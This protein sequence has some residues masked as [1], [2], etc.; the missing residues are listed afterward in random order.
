MTPHPLHPLEGTMCQHDFEGRRLFQHRNMLKWK[1]YGENKRV[2]G[3]EF[4]DECS[5]LLN[6]LAEGRAFNGLG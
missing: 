6:E 2:S 3:F 4:E 1:V 5:R